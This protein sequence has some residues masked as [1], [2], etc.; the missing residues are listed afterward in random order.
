MKIKL[1]I[2]FLALSIGLLSSG[3]SYTRS[4]T[5]KETKIDGTKVDHTNMSQ[6]KKAESCMDIHTR[7]DSS[8]SVFHAA[9]SAGIKNIVYVDVSYTAKTR[10]VIVYGE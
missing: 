4:G 1:A 7:E 5:T 6:Y 2:V 9:E 3:C 10:C 8:L